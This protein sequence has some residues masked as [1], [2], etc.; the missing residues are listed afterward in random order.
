MILPFL[1]NL[2]RF[3]LFAG[4]P[5]SV[6]QLLSQEKRKVR[7]KVCLRKDARGKE[8]KAVNRRVKCKVKSVN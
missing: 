6:K 3:R 7:V 8:D 5:S 1:P 2:F 4:K